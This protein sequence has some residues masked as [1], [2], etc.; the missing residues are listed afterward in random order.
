MR[1]DELFVLHL[2]RGYCHFNFWI[3]LNIFE[4]SRQKC[5][6]WEWIE[7]Q[8]ISTTFCL[9][10]KC[11]LNFRAKICVWI[12]KWR[13]NNFDAK[14][15]NILYLWFWILMPKI[16][17]F[18]EPIWSYVWFTRNL[19]IFWARKFRKKSILIVLTLVWFSAWSHK[20]PPQIKVWQHESRIG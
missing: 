12:K 8:W 7:F 16:Q 6:T 15:Q 20:N 4:F 18:R 5:I 13:G 11:T 3:S 9:T 17:N 10:Y 19:G 14:I 1:V 2:Q